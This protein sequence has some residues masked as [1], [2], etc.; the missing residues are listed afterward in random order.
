MRISR[1]KNFLTKA[2]LQI[3]Q[4]EFLSKKLK[5]LYH[6]HI[7]LVILTVKKLSE[8]NYQEQIKQLKLEKVIKKKVD[9][10]YV[11]QKDSDIS[12]NSWTDKKDIV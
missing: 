2:T 12:Y 3:G 4:K 10:L 6:G 5:I 9:K 1:Y 7:L 8:K 11:K